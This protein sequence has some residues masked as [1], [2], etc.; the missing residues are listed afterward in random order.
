MSQRSPLLLALGAA[1]LL[2]LTGCATGP[3]QPAGSPTAGGSDADP[4]ATTDQPAGDAGGSGGSTG[5]G[6]VRGDGMPDLPLK[7]CGELVESTKTET[8]ADWQWRFEFECDARDAYDASVAAIGALGT[9]EQ[10]IHQQLGSETYLSDWDHF[11]GQPTGRTLDIDLKL[12]GRP[13]DVEI[14][15]LVTLRRND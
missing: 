4:A 11:I 6:P 10:S 1:V 2:G 15:Y 14:V 12:T 9:F 5:A 7:G 8:D 3:A 13:D